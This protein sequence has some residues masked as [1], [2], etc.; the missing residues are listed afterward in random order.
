MAY[1]DRESLIFILHAAV[2]YLEQ[3]LNFLEELREEAVSLSWAE[4]LPF[5]PSPCRRGE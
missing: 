3:L 4:L 5:K 2:K 1:N